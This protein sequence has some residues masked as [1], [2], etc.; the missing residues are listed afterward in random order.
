M[1]DLPRV[2]VVAEGPTDFTIIS[3]IIAS[4][5]PVD[6][7]EVSALQPE[8]SE[9]FAPVENELGFGWA[10]VYRWCRQAAEQ[11]N[12]HAGRSPSL[13]GFDLI[14]VH[15]DADV[16]GKTYTS[17]G[18]D[19]TAGDLPCQR[20]C[21]PAGNTVEALRRVLLRWMGDSSVPASFVLC[22]P[23]KALETWILSAFY[24]MDAKKF[25]PIEC[26]PDPSAILQG[27]PVKGRWVSG[28]RK[29][30]QVYRERAVEVADRWES[31]KRAC[32]EAERFEKDATT[33]WR[34]GRG[35]ACDGRKDAPSLS[36]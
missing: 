3:S 25:A 24:P 15:V 30:V 17:A 31:V 1:S 4:V 11:G 33:A 22:I 29:Q 7:V 8:M 14:V 28:G 32:P 10:G 34:T 16:A 36:K 19:E 35:Q 12:G 27:K 23:S 21:P 18:I 26:R 6:D 9:A 2:G 13:Q 5:L 20:P